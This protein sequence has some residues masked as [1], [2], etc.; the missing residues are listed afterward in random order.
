MRRRRWTLEAD[1]KLIVNAAA[2]ANFAARVHDDSFG[3]PLGA[4]LVGQSLALVA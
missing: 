3:R 2:V 1:A 4:E